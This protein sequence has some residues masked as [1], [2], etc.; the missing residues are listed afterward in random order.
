MIPLTIMIAIFIIA[1]P[2]IIA[3]YWLPAAPVMEHSTASSIVTRWSFPLYNLVLLLLILL[4]LLLLLLVLLLL[5][6]LQIL[7]LLSI[8]LFQIFFNLQTLATLYARIMHTKK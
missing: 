1:T 6:V 2:V 3:R 7:L 5:I 4:L 8:T